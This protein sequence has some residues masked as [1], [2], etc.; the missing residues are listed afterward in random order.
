MTLIKKIGWG[1][2][3]LVVFILLVSFFLPGTVHIERSRNIQAPQPRVFGLVNNLKSYDNWMP[4]NRKDPNMIEISNGIDA[5]TGASYS[6]KSKVKEVGSGTLT[7]TESIPDKKVVTALDF[8]EMGTSFGGW[9]LQPTDNGTKITWFMDA[10]MTGPNFFYSIMGKYMGLFMDK[11]VGPDFEQ[12]LDSLK[13]I[14]ERTKDVKPPTIIMGTATTDDQTVLY[15]TD[16]ASKPEEISQKLKQIYG[17]ELAT[18]IK[19][20]RIHMAGAPMAWY[21]GEQFPFTFAAGVPIDKAPAKTEGRIRILKMAPCLAVVAHFWGP[22]TLDLQGFKAI[23]D[24]LAVNQK[25]AVGQ[26]YEVYVGDPGMERDPYK[27]QTDIY[28]PYK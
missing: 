7:I 10:K 22:Y 21:Y 26:P 20:K 24:W 6:W 27:V 17:A 15:V 5:G 13:S 28:Q 9:T 23:R 1:I 16:S 14:A 19:E 25:T 3:I 11:M 12:G 4:W 18:F 2:A 8:G